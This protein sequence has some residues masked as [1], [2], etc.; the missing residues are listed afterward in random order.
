[1]SFF[2]NKKVNQF[3]KFDH[4]N[5]DYI[6]L[7]NNVFSKFIKKYFSKYKNVIQL[8][9]GFCII[10][11][12]IYNNAEQIDYTKL[13]KLSA[14]IQEQ[15]NILFL[16]GFLNQKLVNKDFMKQILELKSAEN[17]YQNIV[18]LITSP[19][20]KMIS[21]LQSPSN[22]IKYILFEKAKIEI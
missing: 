6:V 19:Q 13:K 9:Q 7:K 3:N 10:V 2:F 22:K 15:K 12:P 16:G 20:R 1:M 17:I 11:Y 8:I 4:L 18:N 5:Y 14:F 21:L